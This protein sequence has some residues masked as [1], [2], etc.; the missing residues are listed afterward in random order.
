M[1]ETRAEREERQRKRAETYMSLVRLFAVLSVFIGMVTAIAAGSGMMTSFIAGT[2]S[3]LWGGGLWSDLSGVDV[4]SSS[5]KGLAPFAAYLLYFLLGL[6]FIAAAAGISRMALWG[7]Y[8]GIL[9]ACY[10]VG[11]TIYSLVAQAGG[12]RSYIAWVILRLAFALA[13]LVLLN[14]PRLTGEFSRA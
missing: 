10:C 9:V 8:L 13:L 12:G 6:G 11:L 1:D 4:T 3:R 7:K 2:A 14:H 5:F